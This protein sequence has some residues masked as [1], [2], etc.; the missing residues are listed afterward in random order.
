MEI[1]FVSVCNEEGIERETSVMLDSSEMETEI[2]YELLLQEFNKFCTAI[3]LEPNVSVP[4][5]EP[6]P[7]PVEPTPENPQP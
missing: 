4:A 3:G 2:T 1:L 5:P 6:T 7:A